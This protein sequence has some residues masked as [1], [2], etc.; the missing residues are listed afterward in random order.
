[1]SGDD[2]KGRGQGVR[3]GRRER[4]VVANRHYQESEEGGNGTLEGE[5]CQGVGEVRGL[6]GDRESPDQHGSV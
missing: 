3:L 1:M 4:H 5:T 6:G 2:G